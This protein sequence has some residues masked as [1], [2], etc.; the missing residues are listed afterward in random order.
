MI[1]AAAKTNGQDN[2]DD[3]VDEVIAA[4]GG[5]VRKA[6][7]GLVRGQHLLEGQ[8]SRVVSAGYVRRGFGREN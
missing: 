7:L 4:A 5:D 3:L 1:Q 8:M 6:I 2:L